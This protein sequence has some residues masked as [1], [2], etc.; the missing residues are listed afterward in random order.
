MSELPRMSKAR[1]ELEGLD[2]K[3]RRER[4]RC[5]NHALDLAVLCKKLYPEE[6]SQWL[7]C[8]SI[9]MD[10]LKDDSARIAWFMDRRAPAPDIAGDKGENA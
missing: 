2:P 7:R 9:L 6:S 10:I 4:L 8:E 3:V 1:K 5:A